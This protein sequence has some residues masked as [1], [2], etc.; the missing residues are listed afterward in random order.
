MKIKLNQAEMDFLNSG[1]IIK[2][3]EGIIYKNLPFWYRVVDEDAGIYE[4]VPLGHPP[5]DLLRAIAHLI[6]GSSI[7]D[8]LY[9]LLHKTAKMKQQGKTWVDAEGQSVPLKYVDEKDQKSERFVQSLITK[10]DIINP[11]I[12]E[13][14]NI[15]I[16][17]LH[18]FIEEGK[19]SVTLYSFD[20]KVKALIELNPEK[21]Q[22]I[23]IRLYS[24]TKDNPTYK[25]YE[26][27]NPDINN[28]RNG[29]IQET[30]GQEIP[31]TS[32]TPNSENETTSIPEDPQEIDPGTH[33]DDGPT[34]PQVH[35]GVQEGERLP[36][37]DTQEEGELHQGDS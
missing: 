32:E 12:N 23:Y 16:S 17:R 29:K 10:V 4:E 22:G 28:P 20:K 21:D 19:K 36:E 9:F 31:K 35:T 8:K 37:P 30:Q 24:A 3:E 7:A 15:V 25:D 13:L 33:G 2:T 26:L 34:S 5:A 11:V 6:D 27:I 14:R 1:T 18:E